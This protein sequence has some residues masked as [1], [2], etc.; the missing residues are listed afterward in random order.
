[1][2]FLYTIVCI[3]VCVFRL[4]LFGFQS[5]NRPISVV[6]YLNAIMDLSCYMQLNRRMNEHAVTPDV[7][8]ASQATI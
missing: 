3:K 6:S 7:F 4:V 2:F 8:N 5:E 1:M